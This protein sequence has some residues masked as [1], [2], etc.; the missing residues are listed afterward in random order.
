MTV[1]TRIGPRTVCTAL[2]CGRMDNVIHSCQL[3]GR[4]VEVRSAECGVRNESPC[5]PTGA[6]PSISRAVATLVAIMQ[7]AS[8][9]VRTL[10]ACQLRLSTSTIDLF[11]MSDIKSL[12][13]RS[14]STVQRFNSS[15][16]HASNRC[17]FFVLAQVQIINHKS[18]MSAFCT[19]HLSWSPG[20]V[21]PLRFLG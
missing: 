14:G 21:L 2:S 15:T 13:R 10:M 1:G 4:T 20:K 8:C 3:T 6:S 11:N 16:N 19:P 17:L 18:Q 5:E 7:N 12:K 9:G